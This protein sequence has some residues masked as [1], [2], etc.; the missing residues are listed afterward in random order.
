MRQ[1]RVLA[2]HKWVAGAIITESYNV[3]CSHF[4]RFTE[5]IRGWRNFKIYEG[6]INQEIAEKIQNKVIEIRDRIDARDESVFIEETQ[7]TV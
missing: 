2:K 4:R 3:D 5:T 6:E 7:I 1:W